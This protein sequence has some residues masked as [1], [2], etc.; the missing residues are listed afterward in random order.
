M[1]ENP[2]DSAAAF[3]AKIMVDMQNSTHYSDKVN[4][5]NFE[6]FG[7]SFENG[8]WR[9]YIVEDRTDEYNSTSIWFKEVI[10]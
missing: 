10:K 5:S 8:M 3:L 2:H 9:F 1:S 7:H 6:T 4:A